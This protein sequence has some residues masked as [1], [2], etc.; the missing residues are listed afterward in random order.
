[1]VRA[2]IRFSAL[3]LACIIPLAAAEAARP[4]TR[5]MTC[6]SAQRLVQ[7]RG[8]VV[9]TTGQHTYFRFVANRGF[10][11]AWEAIKPKRAP[12]R[13]VR[14]CPVGYECYEPLFNSWD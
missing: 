14:Q 12:T 2:T 9:M 8:A 4:D 10:C 11:D 13:D 6:A 5:A 1:M 7:Q 3:A